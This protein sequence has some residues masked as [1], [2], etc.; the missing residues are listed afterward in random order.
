M[1][2]TPT[3]ARNAILS[4]GAT[5]VFIVVG[6]FLY[7]G[8]D[9]SPYLVDTTLGTT[10]VFDP[11]G[12]GAWQASSNTVKRGGGRALKLADGRVL[13]YGG[14]L[15]PPNAAEPPVEV[16]DGTAWKVHEKGIPIPPAR[17]PSP[18]DGRVV[19]LEK[20]QAFAFAEKRTDWY[21]PSNGWQLVPQPP[22]VVAPS[23]GALLEDGRVLFVCSARTPAGTDYEPMWLLF[24]PADRTWRMGA[25]PVAEHGQLA[26]IRGGAL[27]LVDVVDAAPFSYRFD[28]TKGV[29]AAAP[30][31]AKGRH[32]F[33]LVPLDDG[34]VLLLGGYGDGITFRDPARTVKKYAI[35]AGLL[36]WVVLGVVAFAKLR[37]SFVGVG[38]AILVSGV[39]FMFL[40]V[41]VAAA[42]GRP[43][44]VRG[45]VR[46]GGRLRVSRRRGAPSEV[47]FARAVLWARDA[48]LEAASVTAFLRL[49]DAL[50][51]VQA[52]AE[53][54]LRARR[55]AEEERDHATRCTHLASR[56][57]GATFEVE[58]PE[59]PRDP[60]ESDRTRALTELALDSLVDGCLG[61]GLAA[62]G[63]ADAI[64]DTTDA[65]LRDT[66]AVIARDEA[67]H[68]ELSWDVLRFAIDSGDQP[69]RREIGRAVSRMARIVHVHARVSAVRDA[70]VTRAT[71]LLAS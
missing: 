13:L 52:P 8:Q 25:L 64:G 60:F 3:T 49:A 18:S 70:T 2:A 30:A 29:W 36:L 51:A 58:I 66:L 23:A 16:W 62:R 45:K 22:R 11:T 27:L 33:A 5:V 46:P 17:P 20:E 44:R 31:P 34:R 26:A 57:A 54:V 43:I 37:P 55:A 65:E 56:F 32:G 28:A 50:D 40:V 48:R 38:V 53:L 14:T 61:E 69:V 24:E 47:H 10:E 7:V 19:E 67:S 15:R 6:L 63:A 12:V 21:V 9:L 68:A 71:S 59:A 39:A 42:H 41:M 35:E 4:F 1:T